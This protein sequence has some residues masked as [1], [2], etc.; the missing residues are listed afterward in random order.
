VLNV[1][2]WL[3]A[4]TEGG[5]RPPSLF[6]ND[7]VG[8]IVGLTVLNVVGFDGVGYCCVEEPDELPS[9]AEKIIIKRFSV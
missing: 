5:V 9:S 1:S 7:S 3:L 2:Y 8:F 4:L 6:E